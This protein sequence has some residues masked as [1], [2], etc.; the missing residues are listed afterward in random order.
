[1]YVLDHKLYASDYESD[2]DSI[3]SE[4]RQP[5]GPEMDSTNHWKCVLN[6]PST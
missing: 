5:L 3:A 4:N 6:F 2:S 1:M